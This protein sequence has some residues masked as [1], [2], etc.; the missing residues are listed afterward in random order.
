MSPKKALVLL[1]EGAEEMEAVIAIDT[2]RRG[3]VR[4]CCE[5]NMFVFVCVCVLLGI[6]IVVFG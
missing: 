6:C 3:G 2:L 5:F 1:A 4:T